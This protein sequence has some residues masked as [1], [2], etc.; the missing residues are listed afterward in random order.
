VK[1][2]TTTP[3]PLSILIIRSPL[4]GSV[5][6]FTAEGV[7]TNLLGMV[8]AANMSTKRDICVNADLG[9]FVGKRMEVQVNAYASSQ[10]AIQIPP[11]SSSVCD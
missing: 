8:T 1:E 7:Q 10:T 9:S 3:M 6:T 4:S 5:L 2:K 11:E